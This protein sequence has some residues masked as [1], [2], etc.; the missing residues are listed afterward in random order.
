MAAG[1]AGSRLLIGETLLAVERVYAQRPPVRRQAFASAFD[2]DFL[3]ERIQALLSP[4]PTAACQRAALATAVAL[5]LIASAGG[6]HHFTEF[7]TTL[8]V[9]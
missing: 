1:K 7:L 3:R 6:V 5:L 9:G 2:T 4:P 8:L